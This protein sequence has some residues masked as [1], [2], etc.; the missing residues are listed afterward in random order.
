MNKTLAI[1]VQNLTKIYKLYKDPKDR[2]KE[3]LNPFGKK[4]H[5][6][7]YALNNVSFEIKK[8]EIVGIVGRNGSGK[9]T[10]LKIITGVLIPSSGR[11]NVHGKISA[12]LELG[13]GL[14]PEMSGYENIYLNSSINGISKQE[15]DN[16]IDEIVEFSEL[17]EFI[18]QPV[19]SYSSGMRARLGFAIAINV[20]PD[21][22]I[23]D[24]ALAVGDSAF[25]R[26]C[27]AKMEQ[28]KESGATILFVSHSENQIVSLC[29][30]AIWLS[31]GE[32][33]IDGE[34]KL[35]TGLYMKNSQ[36]KHIDKEAIVKEFEKL[37]NGKDEPKK[38]LKLNDKHSKLNIQNSKLSMEEF[39]D[40]SLKPKS[41][42][43]YE[44]KGAKI[45][46]VKI[47]TLDGEKV[48]VLIQG[49]TYIYSYHIQINKIIDNLNC[50]FLIKT[51]HGTSLGGGSFNIDDYINKDIQDQSITVKWYID[52]RLT[53]NNFVINAGISSN[54]EFIHRIVDAYNIRVLPKQ[55]KNLKI[56]SFVNFVKSVQIC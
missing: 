27:F 49:N 47:T 8:G 34:P 32:M 54:S 29:S 35:V 45:S 21:I 43:Y 22:L 37:K 56:T 14:N 39:Y 33:I 46:D 1:K 17:G 40:P 9:S 2:L 55:D 7:F 18:H 24:E 36:K 4:Y 11:V 50:G 16:K 28:I 25:R 3:A 6:D 19:K 51:I 53:A 48:N 23:V 20:E 5:N 13:A 42:I 44:E 41:T 38:N 30:R 10:I 52:M 26:K 31:N 12:I 15:T